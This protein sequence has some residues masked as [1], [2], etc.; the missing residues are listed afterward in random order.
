MIYL[1]DRAMNKRKKILFSVALILPMLIMFYFMDFYR[2]AW[3]MLKDLVTSIEIPK[4]EIVPM[5][6]AF[7]IIIV[8]CVGFAGSI[9][10]WDALSK[11]GETTLPVKQ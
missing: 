9:L 10:L 2:F 4:E 8:S 3:V 1:N 6:K 7:G 5:L 11:D